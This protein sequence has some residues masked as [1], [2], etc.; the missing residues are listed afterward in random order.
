VILTKSPEKLLKEGK[1][2]R[3]PI[4]IG[5]EEDE[6]TLWSQFQFN[7][8]T[9]A[10]VSEYLNLKFFHH[11]TRAQMDEFVGTYQT[12][13]EDGSP[14]R[15]GLLNNWYPQYK[16]VAAILGDLAFT[17]S[18]RYFLQERAAAAP[19][20]KAWSYMNSYFYGLPI[21]GTI[22]GSDIFHVL[23][24][25]PY[26]QATDT[27]RRYYLSFVYH[28]DPNVG[29]PSLPDWP[30]WESSKKLLW[31]FAT[32]QDLRNDDFRKDSY[33]WINSHVPELTM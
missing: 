6:G 10:H 15:T 3:V 14:F 27:I 9:P 23:W 29:F 33:D 16:R 26:D 13:S 30:T 21:I 25:V 17:L 12:I 8:S 31:M 22:H 19:E 18:R 7:L 20:L 2:A 11:A 28:M 4:I 5:D 32:T 24:G 1:F